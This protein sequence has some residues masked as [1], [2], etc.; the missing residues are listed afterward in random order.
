[1][2]RF[3][4]IIFILTFALTSSSSSTPLFPKVNG[5]VILTDQTW[6]EAIRVIPKLVIKYYAP[7]CGHCQALAPEYAKAATS[8]EM[9]EL[10]ITFASIDL[11]SNIKTMLKAEIFGFPV[12]IYYE[13]GTFNQHY[14][15]GRTSDKMIKWFQQH[16][17]T[18]TST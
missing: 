4:F 18:T 14:S 16:M 15:G 5:V 17:N 11:D 7:W 10:G 8:S 1:M 12:I 13:N 9:K 2:K 6:E 3:L